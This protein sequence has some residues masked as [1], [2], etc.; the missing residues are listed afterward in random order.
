MESFASIIIAEPFIKHVKYTARHCEDVLHTFFSHL[1]LTTT[2][3]D[4]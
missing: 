3:L 2:L 1:I 4:G